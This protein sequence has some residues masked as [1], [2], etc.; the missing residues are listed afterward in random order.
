MRRREPQQTIQRN[1][2]QEVFEKQKGKLDTLNLE[3]IDGSFFFNAR[4]YSF[5]TYSR[6]LY[7]Q[8]FESQ[9]KSEK[10]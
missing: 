2:N 4:F 8:K 5:F 3:F 6:V 7:G 1:K 9:E 10:V